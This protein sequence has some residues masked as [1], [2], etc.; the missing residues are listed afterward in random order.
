[1]FCAATEAAVRAFQHTRGLPETGICD[2]A[3]WTALVEASWKFGDRQLILTAPNMRGDDIAELQSRLARLGFDCGRVDGIFGPRTNRALVD[4]QSNCGIRSDGVC[5][6]KTVRAIML[7][8]SQSGDGPGVGA[9]RD[10]EQL[11]IGLASV[12]HCRVVVGQFGG[13]SGLTRSLAGELRQRGATVMSLD[14][15]EAV[16]QAVVANHFNAHAY[17]GFE[18]RA[19]ASAVAYFYQVPTYE[20]AGG[21]ALAELIVDQLN[22]Q[23]VLAGVAGL[24]PT[25]RGRRLPVLRETRMPAV[26]LQVGPV[27]AATDATSQI[28]TAVLHAIELWTLR[29]G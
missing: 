17:V 29:T 2:Q 1:M 22:E 3:T 7:V 26:L 27:R 12:A 25:A 24:V 6:P 23:Q 18:A 10:R 19:E 20:S 14:E 15:P 8:S 9:V 13:L 4:F 21:R 11:R 28:A 5:G 16:A